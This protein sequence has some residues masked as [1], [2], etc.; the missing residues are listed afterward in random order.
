M[1]AFNHLLII[2]T[3][4]LIINKNILIVLIFC[5]RSY[6]HPYS[7]VISERV[8]NQKYSSA[9]TTPIFELSLHSDLSYKPVNFSDII[10]HSCEPILTMYS[11]SFLW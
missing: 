8:F 7:I 3:L 10:L 5:E 4:L 6:S 1:F 2:S 11:K 9:P